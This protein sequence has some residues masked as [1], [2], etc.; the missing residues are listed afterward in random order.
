MMVSLCIGLFAGCEPAA[1]SD[2]SVTSPTA[3]GIAKAVCEKTHF[4]FGVMDPFDTN[5]HHFVIANHGTGVL[6]LKPGPKS[7][8]CTKSQIVQSTLEPGQATEVVLAWQ[9]NDWADGFHHH[10]KIKT[11]DPNNPEIKLEISG[12]VKVNFGANI[13]R[14]RFESVDPD[15]QASTNFVVYSQL[16]D[17]LAEPKISSTWEGA[18]WNIQPASKETALSLNALCAYEVEFISPV[19]RQGAKA[20]EILTVETSRQ[21]DADNPLRL[22]IDVNA[23][24]KRYVSVYGEGITPEGVFEFGVIPFGSEVKK[25]FYIKVRGDQRDITFGKPRIEPAFVNATISKFKAGEAQGL[26]HLDISIP[27]DAPVSYHRKD[28]MG[29]IDLISDHPEEP[30][31]SLDIDFQI[32]E[33]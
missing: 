24:T 8:K 19:I 7:C 31:I 15:S 26:Y 2:G 12:Q 20:N 14:V 5:E 25:R 27:A 10:A 3:T 33:P 6:Q 16:W 30:E 9:A 18:T 1:L 23:T 17:D 11:N 22:E 21:S 13:A 28:N 4:E 32:Y 29:R